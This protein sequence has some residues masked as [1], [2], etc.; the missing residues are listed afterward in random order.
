V[1]KRQGCDH[2]DNTCYRED[3]D[4]QVQDDLYCPM[5]LFTHTAIISMS[6]INVYKTYDLFKRFLVRVIQ[7]EEIGRAEYHCFCLAEFGLP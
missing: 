1:Y 2:E 4:D 7:A 5:V 6:R 3:H